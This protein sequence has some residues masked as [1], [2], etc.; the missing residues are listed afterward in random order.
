MDWRLYFFTKT[1]GA[2]FPSF[3]DDAG[4]DRRW[5]PSIERRQGGR[6][7]WF[8]G[9]FSVCVFE[10]ES[11]LPA[12]LCSPHGALEHSPGPRARCTLHRLSRRHILWKKGDSD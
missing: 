2:S 7:F 10:S 4:S 6:N 9:L 12:R 8:I 1:N 5:Y 3:A 11:A